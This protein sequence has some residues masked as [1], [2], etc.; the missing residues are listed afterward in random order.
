MAKIDDLEESQKCLHLE[1]KKNSNEL[2]NIDNTGMDFENDL[3]IRIDIEKKIILLSNSTGC[4]IWIKKE[5][6]PNLIKYLSSL[7]L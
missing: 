4:C 6:I 5:D 3:S 7:Y 1:M 2:A